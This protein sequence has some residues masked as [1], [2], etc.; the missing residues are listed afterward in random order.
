MRF[1]ARVVGLCAV[2]GLS[3]WLGARSVEGAPHKAKA[4]PATAECHMDSDC[5][6]VPDGCCGCNEGGKQRGI[7]AAA[8]D[9]YEKKRKTACRSSACPALM[10]E[11]PSCVT[12]HAVCKAGKCALGT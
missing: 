4:K 7:P 3:A 6:L 2:V 11:D 12:G 1:P 5:I 9:G 8:R 10:S